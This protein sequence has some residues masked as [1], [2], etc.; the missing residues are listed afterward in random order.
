MLVSQ[1][2]FHGDK[3]AFHL[4]LNVDRKGN[5]ALLSTIPVSL[6]S[7]FFPNTMLSIK[8]AHVA[9]PF[10]GDKLL[11]KLAGKILRKKELHAYFYKDYILTNGRASL[12][13]AEQVIK[14][15]DVMHF[16]PNNYYTQKTES[17]KFFV[18]NQIYLRKQ[19]HILRT[20]KY[21][22]QVDFDY[23][24]IFT[25]QMRKEFEI[26]QQKNSLCIELMEDCGVEYVLLL[27]SERELLMFVSV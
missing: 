23:N 13:L 20:A 26:L 10:S 1:V 5:N 14:F 19:R 7:K 3:H 16:F 21:I 6:L 2:F 9:S 25:K 17:V 4:Y 27:N 11:Q 15:Q 12:E 24:Y 8:Y 22:T 18:I